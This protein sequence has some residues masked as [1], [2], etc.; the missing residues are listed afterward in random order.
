M[1]LTFSLSGVFDKLGVHS[2][3]EKA[4]ILVL[5]VDNAGKTTLLYNLKV[6][7]LV[8]TVV[9]IGFNQETVESRH[10]NFTCWDVGGSKKARVLWRRCYPGTNGL[11]FVVDSA[12]HGE[13]RMA[14]VKE[15]LHEVLAEPDMAHVKLLVMANKQD[16]EGALPPAKLSEALD[17]HSISDREWFIHGCNARTGDGLHEGLGWLVGALEKK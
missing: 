13:E 1:G 10:V 3:N 12:D 15:A 2:G 4:K 17:L 16:L 9:T 14:E 6:G 7:E 8:S 11:V 5:G